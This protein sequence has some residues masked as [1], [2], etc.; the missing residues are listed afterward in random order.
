MSH[1]NHHHHDHAEGEMPFSEKLEKLFRH[2]VKHNTDHATTYRE[3]MEKAKME[4]G[5]K[6][7]EQLGKAAEL[8]G[9]INEKLEEAIRSISKT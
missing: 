2:W 8:T 7:A 4:D 3:W 1:H 6:V 9:K 5:K